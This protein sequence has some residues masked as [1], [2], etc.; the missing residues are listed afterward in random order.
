MSEFVFATC[1]SAPE[2]VVLERKDAK[3]DFRMKGHHVDLSQLVPPANQTG[4]RVE[5]LM[6]ILRSTNPQPTATTFVSPRGRTIDPRTVV[7][8]D[9]YRPLGVG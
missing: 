6:S 1:A 7:P 4:L 2:A 8:P 3:R 9:F 5:S